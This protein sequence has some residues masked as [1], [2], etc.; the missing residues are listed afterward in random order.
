MTQRV[1]IETICQ[2]RDDFPGQ[3]IEW[4]IPQIPQVEQQIDNYINTH[5]E[6]ECQRKLEEMRQGY[7][8]EFRTGRDYLKYGQITTL[9]WVLAFDVALKELHEKNRLAEE[10]KQKEADERAKKIGE[11]VAKKML[12]DY[13]KRLEDEK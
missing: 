13:K 2:L 6:L 10:Q 1:P 3:L 12:D 7:A 8:R 11:E 4:F 5:T 9:Y